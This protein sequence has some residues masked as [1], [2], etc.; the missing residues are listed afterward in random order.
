MSSWLGL[1]RGPGPS[2]CETGL[3]GFALE[4]NFLST[5]FDA[6]ETK[7]KVFMKL[8][9]STIKAYKVMD[10]LALHKKLANSY[11]GKLV[12]KTCKPPPPTRNK[13]IN[14]QEEM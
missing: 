4:F 6:F 3:K 1:R 5:W 12:L 9:Q 2:L 11:W 13:K 10:D 7:Q 14:Y 8:F